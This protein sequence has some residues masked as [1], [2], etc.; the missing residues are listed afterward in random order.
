MAIPQIVLFYNKLGVVAVTVGSFNELTIQE[1]VMTYFD[2]NF[3]LTGKTEYDNEI[4]DI[5]SVTEAV[6]IDIDPFDDAVVRKLN[7]RELDII[8]RLK[9]W[10]K[11]S[12]NNYRM[13]EILT[14]LDILFN[15]VTIAV[16]DYDVSGDPRVG[17]VRFDESDMKDQ[18]PSNT[19]IDCYLLT[20]AG[21][22]QEE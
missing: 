20:F 3:S 5:D 4:F 2:D 19:N 7:K 22:A 21:H 6:Q 16:R 13:F 14:E 11:R 18:S 10:V 8:V 1:S 17:W 15:R 12:T 9:V